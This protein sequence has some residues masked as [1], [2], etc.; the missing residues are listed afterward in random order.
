MA[1]LGLITCCKWVQIKDP[2]RTIYTDSS[3]ILRVDVNKAMFSW[4]LAPGKRF[5]ALRIWIDRAVFDIT[6]LR[7]RCYSNSRIVDS[8]DELQNLYKNYCDLNSI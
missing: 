2:Y 5:F 1:R 6:V 3:T 4:V 7:G 8:C